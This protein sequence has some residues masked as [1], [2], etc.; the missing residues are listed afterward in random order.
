MSQTHLIFYRNVGLFRY[1]TLSNLPLFM[2]A[3]PMLWML[4]GSS[5]TTLHN[6]YRQSLHG[7]S[8][9]HTSESNGS[10]DVPAAACDLPELALPQLVLTIA[11]ASSFHVQIINRI[12]SGYPMWYMT[13]ATWLMDQGTT[14]DSNLGQWAV[15]GMIMYSL[16]QGTLFAN[17]LPPA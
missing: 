16:I 15:R 8:V 9:P 17:F 13:I 5:G 2:L 10:N 7:R 4:L 12:A 11:A 3:L 6:A 1:W 14:R